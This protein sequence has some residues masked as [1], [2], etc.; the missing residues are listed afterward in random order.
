MP[1]TQLHYTKIPVSSSTTTTIYKTEEFGNILLEIQGDLIAPEY[2]DNIQ[3]TKDSGDDLDT[4]SKYLKLQSDDDDFTIKTALKIGK[5]ELDEAQKKV[6]LYIGTSQRLL[7]DL[8]KIN[9][10]LGLMRFENQNENNNGN[11]G[12]SM[13]KKV[14]IVDVIRWKII[15]SGR[16]LPIM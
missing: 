3:S 11:N 10:P 14:E 1:S 8:K 12:N 13:G 4:N 16:P 15:F 2:D 6:T 7:G 9:P 5:L